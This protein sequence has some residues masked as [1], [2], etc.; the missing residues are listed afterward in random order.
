M[1]I[2]ASRQLFLIDRPTS[3]ISSDG[4][5]SP[6]PVSN[7]S[8]RITV[9]VLSAFKAPMSYYNVWTHCWQKSI[10]L[11]PI[12]IFAYKIHTSKTV[13]HYL[14][15]YLLISTLENSDQFNEC[16][17]RQEFI[18][19]RRELSAYVVSLKIRIRIRWDRS[20][21]SRVFVYLPAH[22]HAFIFTGK[23]CSSLFSYQY[24]QVQ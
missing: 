20:P 17:G 14:S 12:L 2:G 10:P 9:S 4:K 7:H 11:F 5:W 18:S 13:T 1:L 22:F 6:T 24:L 15:R 3:M 19:T 23:V 16:S 21:E 8:R